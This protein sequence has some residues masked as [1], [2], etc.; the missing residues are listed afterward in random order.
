MELRDSRAPDLTSPAADADEPRE[1]WQLSVRRL[2]TGD[3]ALPDVVTPPTGHP[4]FPLLDG[5]RAIAA[6]AIVVTHVGFASGAGTSWYGRYTARLDVGVAIFFALAGFLLFRPYVA[7]YLDGVRA[8]GFS[9]YWYRRGLRIIPAYWV[10]L[11]LLAVLGIITLDS[12]FWEDYGL[13]QVYDKYEVLGANVGAWSL[14]VEVAFYAFLPLVVLAMR[15]PRLGSDRTTRVRNLLGMTAGLWGAALVF[16][17]VVHELVNHGP[18]I[19]L[20]TLPAHLDWFAIGMAFAVVSVAVAGGAVRPAAVTWVEE[21]PALTWA[22]AF[23]IFW[24]LSFAVD[25]NGV[26]REPSG[27]VGWLMVHVAYGAIAALIVAPAVFPGAG[28]S[29]VHEILAHPVVSGLGVVSYGIFLYNGPLA[30]W[31][32][33]SHMSGLWAGR[34]FWGVLAGTLS[35]SIAAAVVSYRVLERP[36]LRFKNWRPQQA[37]G[38]A[39]RAQAPEPAPPAA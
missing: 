22:A 26:W 21:N 6:L 31:L 23:A 34:P 4:R 15:S 20:A 10:S 5:V 33:R 19:W 29:L 7:E 9:R 36:L 8:P 37:A 28:R 16:R 1:D 17:V 13:V 27:T 24:Y 39:R 14:A 32:G 12:R 25:T 3:D 2:L 11:T 35:L 30:A 38:R 18:T